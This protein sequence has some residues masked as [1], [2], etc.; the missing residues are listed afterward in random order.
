[1]RAAILHIMLAAALGCGEAAAEPVLARWSAAVA[2]AGQGWTAAMA[3]ADAAVLREAERVALAATRRGELP[4]VAAAWSEALRVEPGNEKAVQALTALGRL[5][6]IQAGLAAEASGHD[7]LEGGA[8]RS[9]DPE[10]RRAIERRERVLR[11]ESSRRGEAWTKADAAAIQDLERIAQRAIAK[12]DLAGARAAWYEVLRLDGAHARAVEFFTAAGQLAA[13]QAELAQQG[14]PHLVAVGAVALRGAAA[15]FVFTPRSVANQGGRWLVRDLAGGRPAAITGLAAPPDKPWLACDGTVSVEVPDPTLVR[16]LP[17]SVAVWFRPLPQSGGNGLVGDYV[18]S[19]WNGFML[20][21]EG[22]SLAAWMLRSHGNEVSICYEL[23]RVRPAAWRAGE[24][25]HAT[26][27]VDDKEL[28]LYADGK[29]AAR[30]AWRGQP[31]PTSGNGPLLIGRYSGAYRGDIAS[32]HFWRR[33]LP[34]A[35][36]AAIAAETSPL[37]R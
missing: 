2:K 1:M 27:T 37:R 4:V 31:G 5:D 29:A 11:E 35:E 23:D 17:F 3:K 14:D 8:P 15:A 26:A 30:Q 33:V 36:V 32:V 12:G 16:Q 22:P 18:G 25:Q 28:V 20:Q 24:W 7:L 13:V 34:P 9:E 21:L 10:L 6:E 19:T